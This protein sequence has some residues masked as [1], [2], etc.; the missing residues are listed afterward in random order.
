MGARASVVPLPGPSA[1]A[2]ALSVAGFPAERFLFAGYVPKKPGRRARYWEWIDEVG[3][4]A[5]IFETPHRIEQTL[6]EMA[7]RWPDRPMLLGRELT[8]I[9]EELLRDTVAQLRQ[10]T[11]GRSWKGEITLVL[12]PPERTG[13]RRESADQDV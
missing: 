7:G 11:Q 9:Y 1:V 12:G 2:A 4:T 13:K 6:T 8:K 5:V 10:A 3:E